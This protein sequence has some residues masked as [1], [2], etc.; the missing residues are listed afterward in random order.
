[1]MMRTAL[2]VLF[3]FATSIAHTQPGKLPP[4]F[5]Q[6]C[7]FPTPDSVDIT[8]DGIADLVVRG[9]HGISTCD[10]PVSVGLCE[11]VVRTLPG[12][13]LLGC[14]DPMGGRDICGFARGDTIHALDEGIRDDLRIPRYAFMDGAVPVLNWSY[15][16]NNIGPTQPTPM[17]KRV[18]VFAT[19]RGE[20]V[21]RGTFTLETLVEQRTVRIIPGTLLA[22]DL[23]V[24]VP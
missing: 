20:K 14:L 7:V 23:P 1:M 13:Q 11:V 3:A 24:I 9:M 18:F 2:L 12:T 17:A 21:V 4:V 19:M 5:F 6:S 10:I 15:G 22:G 16:R 8:G